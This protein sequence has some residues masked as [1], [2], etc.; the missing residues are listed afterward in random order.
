MFLETLPAEVQANLSFVSG[1][2]CLPA[3]VTQLPRV[4]CRVN[5]S[6]KYI[7][8]ALC[9]LEGFFTIIHFLLSLPYNRGEVEDRVF[10]ES[11]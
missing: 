1:P 2:L 4:R 3:A 6:G 11:Q 8:G 10:E 9:P 5:Q 7:P